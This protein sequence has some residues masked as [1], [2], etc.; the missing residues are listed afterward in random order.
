[1]K[2]SA[3][4]SDVLPYML[5]SSSSTQVDI[6]FNDVQL[7][8]T[9]EEYPAHPRIGFKYVMVQDDYLQNST[10]RMRIEKVKTLDDEHT[11]GVFETYSVRTPVCNKGKDQSFIQWKPICYTREVRDVEDSIDVWT[12]PLKNASSVIDDDNIQDSILW[13]YYGSAV[14]ELLLES[15]NISFGTEQDGFYN[16]TKHISW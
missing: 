4:Y 7:N 2:S 13:S 9:V 15:M 3:S 10:E 11:P 8:R 1:M 14:D 12:Y 6:A 5:Y 16:K